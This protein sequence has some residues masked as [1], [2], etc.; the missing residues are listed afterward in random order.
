MR[1]IAYVASEIIKNGGIPIC[2]PIAPYDDIRKEN[3]ALIASLGGTS[4]CT[5]QRL[6]RRVSSATER[7]CMRRCVPG[8]LKIHLDFGSL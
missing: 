2:A 7:V 8:S 1:W 4:L 3:K 6:S 5:L